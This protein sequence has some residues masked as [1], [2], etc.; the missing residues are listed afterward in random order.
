MKEV[1][2]CHFNDN[3]NKEFNINLMGHDVVIQQDP[4]NNEGHGFVVWD[5]GVVFVKYMENNPKDFTSSVL[6]NKTMIDLG[7]GTGIGKIILYYDTL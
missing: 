1:G 7:S 6:S 3:N 2:Y 5:A 4:T